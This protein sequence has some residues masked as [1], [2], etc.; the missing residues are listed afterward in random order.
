MSDVMWKAKILSLIGCDPFLV[1]CQ[2]IGD[3]AIGYSAGGMSRHVCV[4]S[5]PA[6][7]LRWVSLELLL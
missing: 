4:P 5:L 2:R 1:C 6:C 7:R 3:K